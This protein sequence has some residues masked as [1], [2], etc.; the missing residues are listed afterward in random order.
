MTEKHNMKKESME[1]H[2]Y[3]ARLYYETGAYRK[4]Y[5]HMLAAYN[6]KEE[7]LGV[8]KA[9]GIA[10]LTEKLERERINQENLNLRRGRNM[11]LAAM[12]FIILVAF[13]ITRLYYQKKRTYRELLKANEEI[14][15]KQRELNEAYRKVEELSRKDPLTNL[16]NRRDILGKNNAGEDTPRPLWCII[17]HCHG[18]YRRL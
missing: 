5:P 10:K 16:P 9:R 11:L 8:E 3:L 6:L 1:N 4:A 14:K 2:V 15:E 18:R 13:T 7:I 12:G 17:C